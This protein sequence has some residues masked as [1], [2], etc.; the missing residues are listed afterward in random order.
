VKSHRDY[1]GVEFGRGDG[2]G[3]YWDCMHAETLQKR[4]YLYKC[5]SSHLLESLAG[6]LKAHQ[7]NLEI[8]PPTLHMK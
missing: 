1:R 2:I 6:T 3:I 5:T 4:T 7:D 8:N